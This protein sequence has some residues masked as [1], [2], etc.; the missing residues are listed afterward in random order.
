MD[1]QDRIAIIV[2]TIEHQVKLKF[3]NLFLYR[4]K[5][6]CYLCLHLFIWLLFQ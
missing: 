6:L 3:F 1:T 5:G 2:F 4:E